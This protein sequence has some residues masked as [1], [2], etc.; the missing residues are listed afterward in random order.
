MTMVKVDMKLDGLNELTKRLT[1]IADTEDVEKKA[2]E[3]ASDFLIPRI[4]E[5]TPVRTGRMRDS[6]IAEPVKNGEV[7][8]GPSQQGPAFRA[9]FL[10]FGTSKMSA[11]PFMRPTFESNKR[12][13]QRIMAD[14]IR[15]GIA[16]K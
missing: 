9:H 12:Q 5:N 6:I 7:F 15:K 2:L 3:D 16:K 4:K 10:E 1:E 13:I 8:I 11:R 14:A